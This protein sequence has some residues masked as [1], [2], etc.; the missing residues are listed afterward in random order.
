MRSATPASG[1]RVAF[2]PAPFDRRVLDYPLD[3]VDLLCVNETE[4]KGLAG[5]Q[6]DQPAEI[7]EGLAAR[8]PN[9]EIL[10]TLGSAGVLYRDAQKTLR[11]AVP[12]VKAVDTTAAGDTFF[13]YFLAHRAAGL[14]PQECLEI[15]CR[16]AAIC[17]T[18]PGAIASIPRLAEL[19]G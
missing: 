6:T 9:C 3:C 13:G 19:A 5:D 17:V 8:L 18:R 4:G 11:V 7:I 16:A 12:T 14:G 2:N 1:L 10:L 15:A